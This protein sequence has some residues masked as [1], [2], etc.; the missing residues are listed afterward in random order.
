MPPP[1]GELVRF[2]HPTKTSK[3]AVEH[4]VEHRPIVTSG[5]VSGDARGAAIPPGSVTEAIRAQVLEKA[6]FLRSGQTEDSPLPRSWD[7]MASLERDGNGS[8]RSFLQN[9]P[10][11]R[12]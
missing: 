4:A 9:D 8:G 3:D 12:N 5:E 6:P 7:E 11:C 1:L 10:S 2:T